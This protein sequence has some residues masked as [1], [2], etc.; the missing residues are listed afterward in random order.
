MFNGHAALSADG[1]TLYT[2][3]GYGGDVACVTD[4]S[5]TWF[6]VSC[7]RAG[8][9]ACWDRDGHWLHATPVSAACALAPYGS[10][11]IA[12]SEAGRLT[13]V[14]ARDEQS[15]GDGESAIRWDNHLAALPPCCAI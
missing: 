11:L 7:T 10:T 12:A 6:A 3:G 2:L 8:L 1:R 4:R 15:F 9:V 14:T 13:R 5:G